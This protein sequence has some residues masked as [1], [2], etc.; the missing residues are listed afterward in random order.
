L[1][2]DAEELRRGQLRGAERV[3]LA[4]LAEMLAAAHGVS[5]R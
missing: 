2:L 5:T 1:R 4:A 3:K